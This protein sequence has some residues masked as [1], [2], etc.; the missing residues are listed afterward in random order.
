MLVASVLTA[1]AIPARAGA[2]SPVAALPWDPGVD[3]P[4]V[5]FAGAAWLISELE[6]PS[7]APAA[8]RWCGVDA[9]DAAAHR[10]LVWSKPELA[11][12]LSNVAVFGVA[13]VSAVGLLGLAAWRDGH[14]EHLGEDA[15]V[16][17]E[18]TFLAMDVDQAV[19]YAAGRARPYAHFENPTV[20]AANPDPHDANLSFFSGHTT[21]AFAF[22]ISSGTVASMRGYRWA[23]WVW[24]QGLGLAVFSGYLRLAADRHYVTDVLAGAAVGAA[25]GWAIPWLLHR[26][27]RGGPASI[28]LAPVGGPG[29]GVVGRW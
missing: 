21:A 3:A 11:S 29:L 27:G 1:L 5:T 7:L 6:K 28:A 2:A 24:A 9:F 23:P 19:K 8:C 4:L 12:T 13:P 18:A 22:A 15:L 17:L 10:A 14:P 25:M 16:V 26:P 20:L